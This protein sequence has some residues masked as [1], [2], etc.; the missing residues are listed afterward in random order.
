MTAQ[1]VKERFLHSYCEYCISND[2]YCPSPCSFLSFA[3]R[4][5]DKQWEDIARKYVDGDD[6]DFYAVAR[7]ISNRKI[8]VEVEQ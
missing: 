6:I 2:Y 4:L 7:S 5:S 8:V 1:E 3:K